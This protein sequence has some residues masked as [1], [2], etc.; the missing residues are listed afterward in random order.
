[1]YFISC[2]PDIA[3]CN[4][5]PMA[6]IESNILGSARVFESCYKSKVQKIIFA[7]KAFM[8]TATAEDFIAP[9]SKRRRHCLGNM[10]AKNLTK[11]IAF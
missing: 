3:S 7:T 1:M 9:P 2:D 4:K 5:N 8:I 11:D 10:H 6:A